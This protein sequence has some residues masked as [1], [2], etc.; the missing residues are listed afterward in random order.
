MAE[1]ATN[2]GN[3]DLAERCYKKAIEDA[4]DLRRIGD[5]MKPLHDMSRRV[6][7]IWGRYDVACE[8]YQTVLDYYRKLGSR[9]MKNVAIDPEHM[10]LINQN[11]GQYEEALRLLQE[12]LEISKKIGNKEDIASFLNNIALIHQDKGRNDKGSRIIQ[13][14]FGIS[15]ALNNIALI[16]KNRGENMIRL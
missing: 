1:L 2:D 16:H 6:Y 5:M 7:F 10:A 3:L 9:G 4:K 8:N 13:S 12:S 14:L 15:Q 11:R